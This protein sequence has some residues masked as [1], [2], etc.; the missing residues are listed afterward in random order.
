MTGDKSF[1]LF[2]EKSDA[3]LEPEEMSVCLEFLP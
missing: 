2:E 3:F 1:E